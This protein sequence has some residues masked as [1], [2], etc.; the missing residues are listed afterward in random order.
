V[1]GKKLGLWG[2][3]LVAGATGAFVL[4]PPHISGQLPKKASHLWHLQR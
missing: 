2:F 3:A 1:A 4:Y